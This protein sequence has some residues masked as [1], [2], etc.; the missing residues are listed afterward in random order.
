MGGWFSKKKISKAQED[1]LLIDPTFL[2][3]LDTV[4]WRKYRTVYE[5]SGKKV[6]RLLRKLFV[7]EGPEKTF[8]LLGDE[9]VHQ[10][11]H[12]SVALPAVPFVA[13]LLAVV[14]DPIGASLIELLLLMAIGFESECL[15]PRGIHGSSY[16]DEDVYNAVSDHASLVVPFL[17]HQ[18]ERLRME[19]AR[20]CAWMPAVRDLSLPVIRKMAKSG[21][22]NERVTGYVALALLRDSQVEIVFEPPRVHYA[23][24]LAYLETYPLEKAHLASLCEMSRWEYD[25]AIGSL[26]DIDAGIHDDFTLVDYAVGLLQRLGPSAIRLVREAADSGTLL[27]KLNFVQSLAEL[28]TE[29]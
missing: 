12:E 16:Y 21:S 6:E 27:T 20:F 23:S 14:P 8:V 25:P 22:E 28:K 2:Q 26:G 11:W 4:S 5:H 9:L 10:G 18:D 7:G 17:S 29:S 15:G 13:R 24:T 19:A 3:D 1:A